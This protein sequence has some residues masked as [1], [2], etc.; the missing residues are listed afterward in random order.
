MYWGWY[1]WFQQRHDFCWW[2]QKSYADA[3]ESTPVKIWG[4][5]RWCD[6]CEDMLHAFH[7]MGT[8]FSVTQHAV[9]ITNIGKQ[10]SKTLGVLQREDV[11][12]VLHR[13]PLLLEYSTLAQ[14]IGQDVWRLQYCVYM[15]S[16]Y[17]QTPY[18][19]ISLKNLCKQDSAWLRHEHNAHTL[20]RVFLETAVLKALPAQHWTQSCWWVHTCLL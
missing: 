15:H 3:S 11:W 6:F 18:R 1:V 10:E 9:C 17:Y 19:I 14:H 2:T 8:L 16:I 12:V 20:F 5:H 4:N 7:L 13:R